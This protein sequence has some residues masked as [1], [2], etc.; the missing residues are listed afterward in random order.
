MDALRWAGIVAGAVAGGVAILWAVGGY[1]HVRYY[2]RRGHEPET[3]KCQPKR[4]L[5]PD[6]ARQ[7][8]LLSTL[9]LVIGGL[10]TGTGI[11]FVT[12]GWDGPLLYY[13]VADYGWLWTIG[14]GLLYFVIADGV[15]YYA[16]RMMH[17]RWLFRHIHRWH[18]RYVATTPFVVTAMHPVEFL[19]FQAVTLV[20]LFIIPFHFVAVIVVLVYILAFNIIDHSGVDLRSRWPWQGP[21]RY[22]DDHHVYFH[23]NF[24]QHLMFWTGCTGRCAA[25]GGS[26]ARMCSGARARRRGT[27]R[28]RSSWSTDRCRGEYSRARWSNGARNRRSWWGSACSLRWRWWRWCMRGGAGGTT[29]WCGS[30]RWWRGRPTT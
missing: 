22:H 11:Y 8:M 29:C 4:F 5:R 23:V 7:A 13:D 10:I 1:Y 2:V 25:R 9:N 26:T 3:W 17:N 20:W 15:A 28:T 19:V 21:S 16:H 14:G 30:R 6:L 12:E 27:E 24:G 18:H